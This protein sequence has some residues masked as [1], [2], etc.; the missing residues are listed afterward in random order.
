MEL[1]LWGLGWGKGGGLIKKSDLIP[2][3]GARRPH[4]LFTARGL[5][6]HTLIHT[7]MIPYTR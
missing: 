5:A 7:D 3:E 4:S 6:T 2:N 1:L